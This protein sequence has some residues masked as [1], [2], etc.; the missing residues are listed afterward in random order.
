[1]KAFCIYIALIV[2]LLV[3]CNKVNQNLNITSVNELFPLQVGKVFLYRL[4]STVFINFGVSKEIH[5]YVIKDSIESSFI[6]ATGNTSYRIY[7]YITDT[8]QAKPWQFLVTNIATI[9]NGKIEYIEN[10]LRFIKLVDPVSSNKTWKGNIYI[11]T[12][13]GVSPY[14]YFDDWNYRYEKIAEPFTCIKQKFDTTYTVLQSDEQ[15]PAVFDA[16]TFN[17]K[18]YSKEI[19]AKGVGLIY[20]EF[21]F[22]IWQTTPKPAFQDDAYGVKLNLIDYK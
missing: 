13:L 17:D 1:M 16:S 8:L 20:K 6:D 18:R 12:T 19:Y 10:N 21:L 14:Y 7:R 15:T 22:Y 5:S 9:N 2:S 4:D 3:G 11:N